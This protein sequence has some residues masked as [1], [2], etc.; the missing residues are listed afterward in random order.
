MTSADRPSAPELG[1]QDRTGTSG[2][3]RY[4]RDSLLHRWRRAWVLRGAGSV[5]RDVFVEPNVR[6]LRHPEKVRLGERVMLK[7]G[8]RLCPTNPAASIGVGAWTT[9]GHHTFMFAMTSIEIGANCLIAPFCYLID[10]EHGT[11]PGRLIREQSM[12]ARPIRIGND[13]WLGTGVVVT[14]GVTVGDGAVLGARSVITADVPA[15]AIVVGVPGRVI[16][17]RGQ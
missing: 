13:V 4:A 5:G 17:Y 6:L 1:A 14:S 11:E 8:V 3:H 12:T 15:N 2:V 10:N 7:E 9:V 16:R